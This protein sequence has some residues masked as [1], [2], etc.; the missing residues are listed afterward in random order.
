MDLKQEIV[1]LMQVREENY[2]SLTAQ[3]WD[4]VPNVKKAIKETLADN[5][6][7]LAEYANIEFHDCGIFFGKHMVFS[8]ILFFQPGDYQVNGRVIT[9]TEETAPSYKV[10]LTYTV[11]IELIAVGDYTVIKAHILEEIRERKEAAAAE[12]K[13]REELFVTVPADDEL[14]DITE[15]INITMDAQQFDL[16]ELTHEQLIAYKAHLK[17]TSKQ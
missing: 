5:V 16:T 13:A 17:T 7:D 15:Q 2:N 11:P 12:E 4:L 1:A 6:P 14:A 8:V 3:I 10:T 9:I